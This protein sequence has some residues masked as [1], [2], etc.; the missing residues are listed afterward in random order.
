[1]RLQEV[2]EE[3]LIT[4]DAVGCF[5]GEDDE[6]EEEEEEVEVADDEEEE[7]DVGKEATEEGVLKVK[8]RADVHGAVS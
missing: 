2:Q 3:E 6:E 4:V 1:M 5:K 8:P 7:E